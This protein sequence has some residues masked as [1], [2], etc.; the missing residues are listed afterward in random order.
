M[1]NVKVAQVD[2][3]KEKHIRMILSDADG[4]GRMKAMMFSG[5]GTG[6]GDMLLKNSR[7]VNFNLIGRFQINSWQGR[8][9]IEFHLIDGVDCFETQKLEGI[10]QQA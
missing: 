4:G 9:S 8:E 3:L 6:I 1:S 10:S 5:V 7:S 2:V